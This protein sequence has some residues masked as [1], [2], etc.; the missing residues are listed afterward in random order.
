MAQYPE[1]TKSGILERAS[2]RYL[3]DMEVSGDQYV[4][5][6]ERVSMDKEESSLLGPV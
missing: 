5:H 4:M 6:G 1:W 2:R 3:Q